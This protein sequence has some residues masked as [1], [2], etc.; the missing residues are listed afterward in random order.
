MKEDENVHDFYMNVMDYANVFDDL[1]EKMSD[2]KLVRK[3][4][5]SLTKKFDMKVIAIEEA[6]DISTM[7]IDE[8]VGSL[9]TYESAANERLEKKTKSIALMSN[10]EDEEIEDDIDSNESISEAIVL[11]GHKT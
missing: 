2:E 7:R 8:L 5:R 10:V 3:I 6:Q 9:K 11:L 1:G 4:L